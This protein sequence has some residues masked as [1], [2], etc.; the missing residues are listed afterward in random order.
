[1]AK[2]NNIRLAVS[3]PSF[4]LWLILHFRDCSASL[5]NAQARRKRRDC[6]GQRG[7]DLDPARYMPLRHDAVRRAATLD[8]YH[9]Q[10]GTLF[11][12]NNPSSGMYGLVQ[13]VS[14]VPQT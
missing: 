7:K 6:D 9:E 10:N 5:D 14:P 11:P 13:S 1:L 3:N 12:R 4:E 8:R 2:A